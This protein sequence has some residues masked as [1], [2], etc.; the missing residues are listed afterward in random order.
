MKPVLTLVLA[1]TLAG[2][3]V[4]PSAGPA[5]RPMAAVAARALT[6]ERFFA[7][8]DTQ[9]KAPAAFAQQSAAL[10]ALRAMAADSAAARQEILTGFRG[11][12]TLA[13]GLAQFPK[14]TWE[15]RLPLLKRVMAVECRAMGIQAPPLVIGEGHA[16][17]AYFEFDPAHP[18]T[19]R[20]FLYP[21]GLARETDP[22]AALLLLVHETRHSAQ[23]Q[24][25]FDA[26]RHD[27]LSAGYKAAFEAQKRLEG[28]LSFCDFCSLLNEHEAFQTANFV[29]GALTDGKADTSGMGCLSSQ[30]DAHG[31]LKIDLVAIA[32]RLGPAA[33]LAE[34]NRLEQPQFEAF[35]G[36][37]THR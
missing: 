9:A 22:Y 27:A 32:D 1:F 16:R 36:A 6:P 20:V 14:L 4:A 5:V 8:A 35:G 18:G 7:S 28:K 25:A 37:P 29:V 24:R 3:G 26:H 10:P 31:Q 2:C 11:D 30:F 15:E 34:F 33:V 12:K 17:E 19:G 21:E 23:Y 13:A